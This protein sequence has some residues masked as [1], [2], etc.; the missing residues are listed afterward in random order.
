MNTISKPSLPIAFFHEGVVEQLVFAI[1]QAQQANPAH[2]IVL[3]GADPCLDTVNVVSVAPRAFDP[4]LRAFE[5]KHGPR[6]DQPEQP[7]V[8]RLIRWF[9]LRQ[10]MHD[11]G[12]T[13]IY[14]PAPTAATQPNLSVH[15]DALNHWRLGLLDPDPL[16]VSET[17]S[18]WSRDAVEA[19][20]HFLI[21]TFAVDVAENERAGQPSALHA[22]WNS[23]RQEHAAFCVNLRDLNLSNLVN[24]ASSRRA[25]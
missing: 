12:Y 19:F 7:E 14:L 15:G 20:C 18:L 10:C 5:E 16:A 3:L 4:M 11:R 2:P 23:Y 24:A 13:R 8:A 17:P 21:N 25:V 9:H 22:F 6:N 1:E